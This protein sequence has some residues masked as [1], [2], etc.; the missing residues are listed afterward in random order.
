MA[1]SDHEEFISDNEDSQLYQ[2]TDQSEDIYLS[3]HEVQ[4]Q[5]DQSDNDHEEAKV[6]DIELTL[7]EQLLLTARNGDHEA[8]RLLLNQVEAGDITLD[9]N[10]IGNKIHWFCRVYL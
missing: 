2:I 10:C 1:E 7:E 4:G 6:S 5:S 8:V 9:V 3:D